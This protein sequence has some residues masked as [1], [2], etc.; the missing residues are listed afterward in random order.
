MIVKGVFAKDGKVCRGKV[1]STKK[2]WATF[3]SSRG[4]QRSRTTAV[5]TRFGLGTGE[6]CMLARCGSYRSTTPYSVLFA[7]DLVGCSPC[8]CP[9][10]VNLLAGQARN[11]VVGTP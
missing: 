2:S 9:E 7:D 6:V 11:R 3:F 4:D 5:E 8:S 1:M 10:A